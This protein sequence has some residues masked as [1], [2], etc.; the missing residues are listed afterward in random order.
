MYFLFLQLPHVACDGLSCSQQHTKDQKFGFAV[1][2]MQPKLSHWFCPKGDTSVIRKSGILLIQS[3]L[4]Y[5]SG[6]ADNNFRTVFN[7]HCIKG[8]HHCCSKWEV[9]SLLRY[10]GTVLY[11]M[12]NLCLAEVID[13]YLFHFMAWFVSFWYAVVLS[14]REGG[15]EICPWYTFPCTKYSNF[16]FNEVDIIQCLMLLARR[17]DGPH[18]WRVLLLHFLW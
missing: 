11:G 18:S 9:A 10:T 14:E 4:L 5:S 1:A 7:G 17:Q 6:L 15:G 12:K 2:V 3:E 13:F 8:L 16:Y